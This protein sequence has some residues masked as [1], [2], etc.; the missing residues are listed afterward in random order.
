MFVRR[1]YC[2]FD[3]LRFGKDSR[4]DPIARGYT[5]M[6]WA[7]ILYEHLE[8]LLVLNKRLLR[9]PHSTQGNANVISGFR[10]IRV[11]RAPHPDSDLQ[12]FVICIQCPFEIVLMQTQLSD[13]IMR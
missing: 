10:H 9:S 5:W 7:V 8:G 12:A 13:E 11:T 1:I 4:K 3:I 2:P 6:V